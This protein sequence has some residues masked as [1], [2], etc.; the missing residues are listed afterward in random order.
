M[1]IRSIFQLRG[2]SFKLKIRTLEGKFVPSL[3]GLEDTVN[4]EIHGTLGQKIG[5]D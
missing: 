4:V 5:T 2:P 3:E 1:L